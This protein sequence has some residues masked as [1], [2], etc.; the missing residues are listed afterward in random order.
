MVHAR[1]DAET[2]KLLKDLERRLGWNDSTIVRE[3]IKALAGLM[4]PLGKREIIGLGCFQSGVDDLGS[5]KQHLRGFG[6]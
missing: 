2:E 6:N 5:N 4:V 3:G 1:I